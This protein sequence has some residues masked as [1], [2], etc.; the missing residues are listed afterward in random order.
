MKQCDDE[1]SADQFVTKCQKYCDAVYER[2]ADLNDEQQEDLERE[3]F[4][5][6][7]YKV[8]KID[9]SLCNAC[10]ISRFNHKGPQYAEKSYNRLK[11][12][13]MLVIVLDLALQVVL[14]VLDMRFQDS[15]HDDMQISTIM[16]HS[17]HED[18][19]IMAAQ[20]VTGFFNIYQIFVLIQF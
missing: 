10:C 20:V 3:I 8:G 9:Y 16:D 1:E 2:M 5:A 7:L 4:N 19:P 11:F 12:T 13:I 15:L 18:I 14:T 6:M 17:T